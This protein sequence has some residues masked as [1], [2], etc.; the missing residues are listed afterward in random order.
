MA[1]RV[2]R[3][4]GRPGGSLG[5]RGGRAGGSFLPPA[6]VRGL[7]PLAGFLVRPQHDEAQHAF[8]EANAALDAADGSRG[9]VE[10]TEDVEAFVVPGD[11]VCQP[12]PLPGLQA[13]DLAAL[14]LHD[15]L[16][17]LDHGEGS[18]VVKGRIQNE[19]ELV[20]VHEGIRCGRSRRL[21]TRLFAHSKVSPASPVTHP[22]GDRAGIC[23]RFRIMRPPG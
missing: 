19:H 16:H 15:A 5:S 10:V 18:G 3:F 17:A 11:G 12:P 13:D 8:G 7:V 4:F 20:A 9:R 6:E 22:A 23:G 21:G 14:P 2:S 1:S